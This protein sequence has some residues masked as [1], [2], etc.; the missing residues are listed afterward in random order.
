MEDGRGEN[1]RGFTMVGFFLVCVRRDGEGDN[2]KGEV[3]GMEASSFL[4]SSV[5]L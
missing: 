4:G 5:F 2:E 3:R 1:L